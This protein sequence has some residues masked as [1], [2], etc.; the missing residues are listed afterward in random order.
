MPYFNKD[1]DNKNDSEIRRHQ[2]TRHDK[3]K[4][5]D[6]TTLFYWVYY[7]FG[8]ASRISIPFLASH[9]E[10]KYYVNFMNIKKIASKYM[11]D[12]S[13]LEIF[14]EKFKQDTFNLTNVRKS[15]INLYMS[16]HGNYKSNMN[17][18]NWKK[19]N[20]SNNKMTMEVATINDILREIFI[21]L[22]HLKQEFDI[23]A[24]E[25]YDI[26]F[27]KTIVELRSYIYSINEELTKN[28]FN[29][30][31]DVAWNIYKK[32]NFSNSSKTIRKETTVIKTVVRENISSNNSFTTKTS[33]II[34]TS[35]D[36][37]N[38]EIDETKTIDDD[39][40]EIKPIDDDIDEIKPIDDVV[41]F[42]ES[43]EI[44]PMPERTCE[45]DISDC[46][47]NDKL[48]IYISYPKYNPIYKNQTNIIKYIDNPCTQLFTD[49][50]SL[51]LKF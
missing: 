4:E 22:S 28:L 26:N 15:Y 18:V 41:V 11:S 19:N 20:K 46:S 16:L 7:I 37:I 39:I 3:L 44:V 5:S 48:R 27:I 23:H 50:F 31:H 17:Y 2:R 14:I 1:G 8:H 36:I 43:D 6:M 12:K 32:Y 25:K 29:H 51:N 9:V 40:D 24:S 13:Q 38:D 42:D 49:L 45:Y 34:S 33:S 35:I 10:G 30:Y 21:R 47:N